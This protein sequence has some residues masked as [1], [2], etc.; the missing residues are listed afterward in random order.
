M[1][2]AD[3]DRYITGNYGEDQFKGRGAAPRLSKLQTELI[4]KLTDK[5]QTAEELMRA[6]GRKRR[7]VAVLKRLC[8]KGECVRQ[9]SRESGAHLWTY[10]LPGCGD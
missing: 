5:W 10:R 9:L 7:P 1:R 6:V 2:R 4:A 3:I 8:D